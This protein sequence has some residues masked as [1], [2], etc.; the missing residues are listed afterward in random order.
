MSEKKNPNF[1][2]LE[3]IF[4][5]PPLLAKWPGFEMFNVLIESLR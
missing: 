3:R 4:A 1:P 5:L 2:M